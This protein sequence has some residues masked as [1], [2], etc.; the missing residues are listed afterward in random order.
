MMYSLLLYEQAVETLISDAV[1]SVIFCSERKYYQWP[2]AVDHEVQFHMIFD[3]WSKTQ[4]DHSIYHGLW[5][6]NV[7]N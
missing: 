7:Y 5:L 3:K 1:N 4:E 2:F 6:L